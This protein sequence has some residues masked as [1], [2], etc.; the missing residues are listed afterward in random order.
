MPRHLIPLAAAGR[1]CDPPVTRSAV[2]RWR[3]CGW[4][5]VQVV[6]TRPFT[7]RVWALACQRACRKREREA[8]RAFVRIFAP[9]IDNVSALS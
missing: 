9:P 5:T 3:A 4:L 8:Q 1:L 2:S 7:T 6:G